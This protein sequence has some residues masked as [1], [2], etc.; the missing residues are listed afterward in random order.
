MLADYLPAAWNR[1]APL[2]SSMAARRK[3]PQRHR[4]AGV[5]RSANSVN[6]RFSRGVGIPAS[7][8]RAVFT[9]RRGLG[10]VDWARP[11]GLR[12]PYAAAH[13]SHADLPADQESP[14]GSALAGAHQAR[15]HR[16]IP[17]DRGRRCPGDR[18]TNG[19]VV[20]LAGSRPPGVDGRGPARS[21][22]RT[23]CFKA[24]SCGDADHP[25]SMQQPT[26]DQ[27]CPTHLPPPGRGKKCYALADGASSGWICRPLSFNNGRR[28]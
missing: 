6:V 25:R 16:Q 7:F 4:P 13:R 2:A 18:R 14:D 21:S 8:D 11:G 20:S 19:G 17:R 3:I 5:G 12:H 28:P 15:K 9:D 24:A 10:E 26:F 22:R 27:A 23:S 1:Q